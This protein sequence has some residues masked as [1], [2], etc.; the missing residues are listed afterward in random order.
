MIVE[1][2]VYK[3]KPFCEQA[4]LDFSKEVWAAV[5]S[6]NTQRFYR[7]I[8]G[9]FNVIYQEIEFKDL[10]EREQYWA[11]FFALPQTAG[12]IEKWKE[13]TESGGGTEF[14]TLVE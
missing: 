6:P 2:R 4:A 13:L 12:W 9:P 5:G 14:L 7:P 1:R 10:Q 3:V 11:D 8:S